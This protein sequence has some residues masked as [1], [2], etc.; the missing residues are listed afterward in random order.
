MIRPAECAGDASAF[1]RSQDDPAEIVIEGVSVVEI[2]DVLGD[3]LEWF[4]K[5]TVR[6][7]VGRVCVA[8]GVHVRSS[9]VQLRVDKESGRIDTRLV[10]AVLDM[11]I[12]IHEHEIV[13]LDGGEMLRK[14]IEPNQCGIYGI[15]Q[16]NV[17]RYS[18]PVIVLAKQS[19]RCT[20]RT[21]STNNSFFDFRSLERTYLQPCVV[22]PTVAPLA[23][24]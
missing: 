11:P 21:V 10:P 20:P 7:A 9:L 22:S 14:R 24:P 13:R 12:L 19:K 17:T 4:A 15:T 18:Q 23:R 2:T 8:R 3:H 5:D 16:R 1:F 6:D